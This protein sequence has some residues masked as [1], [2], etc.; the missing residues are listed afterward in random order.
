MLDE[1]SCCWSCKALAVS[2]FRFVTTEYGTVVFN[3]HNTFVG[4]YE[5][6]QSAVDMIKESYLTEE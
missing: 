5:T 4:K 1:E 3:R 2:D 6:E